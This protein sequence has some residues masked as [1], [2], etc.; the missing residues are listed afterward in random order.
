MHLEW[1]LTNLMFVL[2]FILIFLIPLVS[3][4]DQ[5]FDFN[6]AKFASRYKLS[7][8]TI[9]SSLKI[10]Q[11]EGYLEVTEEIFNPSKIK[12]LAARDE[13]YRFQIENVDFDAFIKLLLRTYTG[14]FTDFI[15]IYE[16]SL[17][18]KAKVKTEVIIDYLK[19][20]NSMG[21]I[22]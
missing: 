19:K 7:I 1:V 8:L 15:T 21:I 4:K 2:S 18:L 9:Y 22:S 3:A 16:D 13:L 17:A 12:F 14:V 5:V 10:L 11:L 6:I 20:L